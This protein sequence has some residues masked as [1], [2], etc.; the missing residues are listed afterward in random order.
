MRAHNRSNHNDVQHVYYQCESLLEVQLHQLRSEVLM[1]YASFLRPTGSTR[2]HPES[3]TDF[4]IEIQ[5]EPLA[6]LSEAT[7]ISSFRR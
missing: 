4:V 6:N 3:T 2:D 5:R 1:R 7:A